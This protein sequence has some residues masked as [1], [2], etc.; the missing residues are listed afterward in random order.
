MSVILCEFGTAIS[1]ECVFRAKKR[2][3]LQNLFNLTHCIN[4]Y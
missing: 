1:K 3:S 4:F 2:Q